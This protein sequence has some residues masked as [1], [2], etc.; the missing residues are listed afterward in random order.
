[1]RAISGTSGEPPH[2]H[3]RETNRSIDCGDTARMAAHVLADTKAG[4]PASASSGGPSA[5]RSPRGYSFV[6]TPMVEHSLWVV[7]R[8]CATPERLRIRRWHILFLGRQ[9]AITPSNGCE[10]TY[11][12]R[13]RATSSALQSLDPMMLVAL[14]ERQSV[15][16]ATASRA[17]RVRSHERVVAG[18]S[19]DPGDPVP[20]TTACV[21]GRKRGRVRPAGS[22]RVSSAPLRIRDV[23]DA[24]GG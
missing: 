7:F 4:M 11:R 21:I 23:R 5:R 2:C 13:S 22:V 16:R 14:R 15:Y 19:T 18:A 1:M 12:Y 24:F 3:K 9:L 8:S 6:R 20:W 17:G 10:E